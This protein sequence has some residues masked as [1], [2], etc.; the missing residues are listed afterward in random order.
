MLGVRSSN[1]SISKLILESYLNKCTIT[2]SIVLLEVSWFSFNNKRTDFDHSIAGS[3]FSND[4]KLFLS[5][6][7]KYEKSQFIY[8]SYVKSKIKTILFSFLNIETRNAILTKKVFDS[9]DLLLK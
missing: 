6:F 2:P 5:N 4:H 1:M 8:F 3:L 9:E 7:Y